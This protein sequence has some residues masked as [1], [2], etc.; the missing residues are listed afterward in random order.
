MNT[1]Q[2]DTRTDATVGVFPQLGV[3][4]STV[5]VVVI[6][7]R[8]C[9]GIDGS[10]DP[11]PGAKIRPVDVPWDPD[12]DVSS[13]KYPGD[14]C[15]RKPSTDVII[16]G[17]AVAREEKPTR[18]L[19]VHVRVGPV[20]KRIRV[21]G[22]R[23]WFK[24]LGSYA[25]TPPQAFVRQPVK[26]E[27]AYGGMDASDPQRAV[28]EP[29]N[30]MGTGVA[31]DPAA[32]VHRPAPSIE[33]PA[34]LI[35][36]H[37]SRPAP[38]GIAAIGPN[39]QPRQKYAG[40]MDQKWQDER[41]PI[42]PLDFDDRFNHVAAPGM[43]APS[44]LRGGEEV[45]ITSMHRSGAVAFKLPRRSFFVGAELDGA[46]KEARPA[47]DTVLIEPTDLLMEM[48][49]RSAIPSPRPAR[50]LRAIQVFEKASIG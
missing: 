11:E 9:L 34:D 33:D 26:W 16:V 39:F 22:L 44:Y 3:D 13:P 20:E 42:P 35:K 19:D 27:S 32:L 21:F 41:M 48:T 50:R 7:Q 23:V 5:M 25:L 17:Y 18:E 47:L 8:F 24:S 2:L 49:W 40:T 10:V 28:H 43:I 29:R 15:I 14:L 37:R 31:G 30:P 6:K 1:P 12:A 38:A 4:G 36:S 45:A 46:L